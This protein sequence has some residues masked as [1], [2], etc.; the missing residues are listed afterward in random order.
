MPIKQALWLGAGGLVTAVL[1]LSVLAGPAFFLLQYLTQLPL[2]CVGLAFGIFSL[3]AASLISILFTVVAD[4]AL[5]IVLVFGY[6]GPVLASEVSNRGRGVVPGGP[7]SGGANDL[8]ADSICFCSGLV[9]G[10]GRRVSRA[11]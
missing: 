9:F 10:A 3:L 11:Y 5:T 8:C 2:L 6:I 7:D 1:Y 4:P